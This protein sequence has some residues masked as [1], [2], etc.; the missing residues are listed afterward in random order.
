[1]SLNE[2]NNEDVFLI[3]RIAE[4]DTR[5]FD[6]LMNVYSPRLYPY[7]YALVGN[8]ELAEEV[9]SDVF[10]DVWRM[11]KGIREIESL[12]K[13]LSTVVYRK[14]VSCIRRESKR[15]SVSLDDVQSF[16]FPV[17]ETASDKIISQE[18][19]DMLNRAID[20]LPPKCKHVFYLAKIECLPYAEICQQLGISLPT[21]D[22][23]VKY[24]MTTLK[25]ILK[26]AH[27]LIPILWIVRF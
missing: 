18:E 12:R 7:A 10:V 22:Y 21:V 23:H 5:A 11:G 16:R 13:F 4:G 17:I 19:V 26:K 3:E 6:T 8:K 15:K 25:K 24:A 2:A 14:S 27:F 1:M 20:K 9:V